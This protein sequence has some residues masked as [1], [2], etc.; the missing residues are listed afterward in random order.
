M[1]ATA[2]AYAL[3][4]ADL[5]ARLR[6]DGG[7]SQELAHLTGAALGLVLEQEVTGFLEG[8]ELRIGDL[9]R[10]PR[11]VL[12]RQEIV[13]SSPQHEGRHP[14]RRESTLVFGEIRGIERAVEL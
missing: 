14:H 9:A 3:Q 11:R 5:G 13:L 1:R 10:E 4:R 8:H 2:E 7:A 6:S 12:A